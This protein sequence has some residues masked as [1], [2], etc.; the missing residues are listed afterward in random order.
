MEE[1]RNKHIGVVVEPKMRDQLKKL[2][3]EKYMTL[4][5]FIY[6]I[7]KDYLKRKENDSKE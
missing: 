7:L 3:D 1:I 6:G 5:T 4:S 2:A